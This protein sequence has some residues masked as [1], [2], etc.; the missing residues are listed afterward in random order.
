MSQ[1]L[2]LAV[3]LRKMTHLYS[4]AT[5][6]S[7]VFPGD[8]ARA[9]SCW[10]SFLA[11][12]RHHGSSSSVNHPT[13]FTCPDTHY[14]EGHRKPSSPKLLDISHLCPI[15]G[16]FKTLCKATMILSVLE[17]YPDKTEEKKLEIS[18]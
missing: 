5:L 6:L 12:L 3:F 15:V 7:V 4:L 2:E 13:C 14:T 8:V 11:L 9:Y 10:R 17:I 18:V 16:H 1:S